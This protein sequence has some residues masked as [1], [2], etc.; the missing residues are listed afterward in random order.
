MKKLPAAGN[1]GMMLNGFVVVLYGY[2]GIQENTNRVLLYF[3]IYFFRPFF[4]SRWSSGFPANSGMG[5]WTS[6]WIW[7]NF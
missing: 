7:L 2:L 3:I 1:A 6:K 5:I 4:F